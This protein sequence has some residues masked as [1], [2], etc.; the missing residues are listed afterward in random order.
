MRGIYFLRHQLN[1]PILIHDSF[2]ESVKS[3]HDDGIRYQYN[4][5]GQVSR[6]EAFY[7]VNHLK[8]AIDID[9]LF[10]QTQFKTS[11]G[12]E[13]IY[14]FD[15][16]GHTINVIDHLGNVSYY[17]YASNFEKTQRPKNWNLNHK[18]SAQIETFNIL[19]RKNK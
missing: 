16:F 8:S 17:F 11:Q 13:Y 19:D 18:V 7:D 15:D 3:K 14:L 1:L 9:Y 6:I 12:Q 5:S 10:H 4:Q 2:L